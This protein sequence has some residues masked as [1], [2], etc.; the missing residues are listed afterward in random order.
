MEIAPPVYADMRIIGTNASF[1]SAESVSTKKTTRGKKKATAHEQ[2][3]LLSSAT[4]QATAAAR[5]ILVS[6]GTQETALSTA[7]AAAESVLLPNSS[8]SFSVFSSKRQAKQQAQVVSSMALLQALSYTTSNASGTN[9]FMPTPTKS[10]T[11]PPVV[12][13]QNLL[14]RR[15]DELSSVGHSESIDGSTYAS[16]KTSSYTKKL[17]A[18]SNQG[19]PPRSC[20]SPPLKNNSPKS[21]NSPKAI[22]PKHSPER[23]SP[24]LDTSRRK[25]SES[26]EAREQ[27]SDESF[28]PEH[29]VK[30]PCSS[31]DTEDRSLSVGSEDHSAEFTERDSEEEVK[32]RRSSDDAFDD[33]DGQKSEQPVV[34]FGSMFVDGMLCGGCHGQNNNPEDRDD[35]SGDH[36][37]HYSRRTDETTSR[38]GNEGMQSSK[39]SP[40]SPSRR[41]RARGRWMPNSPGTKK[42][43][44]SQPSF[45]SSEHDPSREESYVK[46]SAKG[47]SGKTLRKKSDR[48]KNNQNTIDKVLMEKLVLHALNADVDES[49]TKNFGP[50]GAASYSPST[51][52]SRKTQESRA[53][54]FSKWIRRKNN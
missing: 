43:N 13:S 2:A 51:T 41:F 27:N 17:I 21:N 9:I 35:M 4:S 19:L 44:R 52:S 46:D 28:R 32:N 18:R 37:S 3:V 40:T 15:M 1:T 5:S 48:K 47:P 34:S 6:G 38:D 7:R 16:G 31:F 36:Q 49:T 39:Q 10:P 42:N 24:N 14:S 11:A 53:S 54:R 22:P 45:P 30:E 8:E 23:W 12:I 50:S 26:K 25:I 29:L 33:L 20:F